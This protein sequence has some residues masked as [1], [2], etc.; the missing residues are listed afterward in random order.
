MVW[1]GENL[2]NRFGD[3]GRGLPL[4]QKVSEVYCYG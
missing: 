3:L 4:Q 1:G 2:D